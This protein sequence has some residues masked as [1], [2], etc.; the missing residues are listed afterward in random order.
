MCSKVKRTFLNI[1]WKFPKLSE[2]FRIKIT[3]DFWR[4]SE[5]VL[6]IQQQIYV[7]LKGQKNYQKCLHMLGQKWYHM[8]GYRFYQFD[9]TQ[10]I[11]NFYTIKN[12]RTGQWGAQSKAGVARNQN[13]FL[14][15]SCIDE[16]YN[17]DFADYFQVSLNIFLPTEW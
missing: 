1:F 4:R 2:Y 9:P 16:L 11:T 17:L 12:G 8:R 13:S 7:Q 14:V 15:N 3:E 6:I 10:H 5:D